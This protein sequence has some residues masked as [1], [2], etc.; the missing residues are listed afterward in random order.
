MTDGL[1]LDRASVTY[2][3]SL[4]HSLTAV[5]GVSLQIGSGEVVGLVGESG[6][7]KSTLARAVCGLERLSAG[8]VS[9]DGAPVGRLGLRK[10]EQSLLRIQMI[11][12]NPYAS[13]NPRR[14]IG[15]QI[16]DAR[17]INPGTPRV[18]PSCSPRSRSSRRRSTASRTSSPAASDSGSRSPARSPPARTC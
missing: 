4:G 3:Q 5:D 2:R 8:S 18:W 14:R 13:L 15:Q 17:K 11:F 1:V 12:Q 9:F 16:E 7:G 6:C 10:R